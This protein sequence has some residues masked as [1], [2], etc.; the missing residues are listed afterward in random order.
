MVF[1]TA[2]ICPFCGCKYDLKPRELQAKESIELKRITAEEAEK[3]EQ[4]RKQKR[5]EQ[6]MAKSYQELVAIGKERGYKNPG[7]WAAMVYKSRKR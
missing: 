5:R 2:P 1:K 6:G 7:A 4:E 3:A